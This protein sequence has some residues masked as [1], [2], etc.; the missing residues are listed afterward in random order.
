MSLQLKCSLAKIHQ[1]SERHFTQMHSLSGCFDDSGQMSCFSCHSKISHRR[2]YHSDYK[3]DSH[4]FDF[5]KPKQ[6]AHISSAVSAFVP[7][8]LNWDSPFNLLPIATD[9]LPHLFYTT[10]ISGPMKD[11]FVDI[12]WINMESLQQ[13]GT[14]KER[15]A[16]PQAAG[17]NA[18]CS[19]A[20]KVQ[21]V[22]SPVSVRD[23][24]PSDWT[25][26]T[27]PRQWGAWWDIHQS[28]LCNWYCFDWRQALWYR[29]QFNVTSAK[30]YVCGKLLC[31]NGSLLLT[32]EVSSTTD[33]ANVD[34]ALHPYS[35]FGQEAKCFERPQ[36]FEFN[37]L[38]IQ[39]VAN[40]EG[41]AHD[42]QKGIMPKYKQQFHHFGGDMLINHT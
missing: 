6:W 27:L 9:Y 40:L 14:K 10:E 15:E 24:R 35:V 38:A 41:G 34:T 3:Y 33:F 2:W 16:A 22:G 39:S 25:T 4:I 19:T 42:I 29:K 26:M 7:T 28:Q 30:H 23:L 21:S 8:L 17:K 1:V 18:Y 12:T 11:P 20:I 5:I 37:N 36:V 13:R 31:L 32:L